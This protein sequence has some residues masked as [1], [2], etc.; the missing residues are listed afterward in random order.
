MSDT[1]VNEDLKTSPDFVEIDLS[2]SAQEYLKGLLEK[3]EDDVVGIRI[4]I[5]DPGTPKAL[6]WPL[7]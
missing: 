3:Q 5:N 1:P 7:K 4:F 2:E 6:K